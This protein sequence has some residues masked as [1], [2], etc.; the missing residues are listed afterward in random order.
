MNKIIN[1]LKGIFN[2]YILLLIF[3]YFVC[4][5]GF[6]YAYLVYQEEDTFT[7]AG[8][9]VGANV[10]VNVELIV[11]NNGK[12]VPMRDRGLEDAIN[13][14]EGTIMLVD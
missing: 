1:R 6:S 13:A 8:N 4:G 10:D 3:T 7:I 9:I 11:G 5:V 12:L 2:R 14:T